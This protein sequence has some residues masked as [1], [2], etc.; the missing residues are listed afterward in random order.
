VKFLPL[1]L[2]LIG[3]S[4]VWCRREGNGIFICYDQKTN[5]ENVMICENRKSEFVFSNCKTV[6]NFAGASEKLSP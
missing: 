2:L 4:D 3:C 5:T 1:L 6:D